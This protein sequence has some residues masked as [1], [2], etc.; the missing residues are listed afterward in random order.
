MSCNQSSPAGVSS[1]EPD[2]TDQ[3]FLD[4][5]M[6]H[7]DVVWSIARRMSPG[8]ADAEDLVQETYARAWRGFADQG[9]GDVR[10]WLVAICLNAARSELRRTRRR[11]VTLIDGSELEQHEATADVSADALASVERQAVSRALAA[12]PEAQRR[13][14][15]LVDIGGLTAREAAEIEGSPRGTILARLHRGR[16]QL[17]VLADRKGLH[18]GP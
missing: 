14:I 12:L 15:V 3:P 16:R 9:R 1:H 17:A 7:L 8:P 2:M 18:R 11:P 5:T 10:S 4:A 6:A 13:A